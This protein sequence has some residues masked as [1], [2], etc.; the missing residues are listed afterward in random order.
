MN[1]NYAHTSARF[2]E[3]IHTMVSVDNGM[4]NFF[5]RATPN[6]CEI[7]L[8]LLENNIQIKLIM[9]YTSKTNTTEA[10]EVNTYIHT[11]P[12]VDV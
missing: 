1:T 7:S 2:R 10:I 9:M 5:I 4:F 8:A 11:M 6:C 3:Y 12:K